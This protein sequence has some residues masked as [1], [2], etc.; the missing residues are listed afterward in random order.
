MKNKL[1]IIFLICLSSFGFADEQGCFFDEEPFLSIQESAEWRS[2]LEAKVGYFFF[3]NSKMR[4][5]FDQGGIDI[6]L[7]GFY[8]LDSWLQIYGSV[9]YL[10]R[11]GRSLGYHQKTKIWETPLSLGLKITTPVCENI[12]GY[13]T[14][15]P[16]YFFVCVHNNSS[17]VSKRMKKNGCGGFANI[18]FNYNLCNNLLIDFF[19]EYS[20]GRLH[21]HSSK[22]N[23][24]GQTMQVG[25]FTFGAGL[26]Y[27]FNP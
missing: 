23:S 18:G 19:G 11:S 13:F 7:S 9:E 10:E 20:Y 21:F 26:S 3:S 17:F 15:G 24:Y 4:K 1:Y 12:Q 8:P 2:G 6:Q 5:V 14:L 16:R 22:K 25:G 27:L